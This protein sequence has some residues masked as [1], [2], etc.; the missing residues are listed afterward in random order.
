M[1]IHLPKDLESS[2]EAVVNGGHFES[3][4]AAMEEAVRMLIRAYRSPTSSAGLVHP[5]D[6][7]LGSIGAMAEVAELLDEIVA[8]AYRRRA[9][10]ART[11]VLDCG[12]S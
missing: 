7:A 10:H 3:V 9:S 2:V 5:H 1:T 4:D 11:D 8:E 12:K 6:P